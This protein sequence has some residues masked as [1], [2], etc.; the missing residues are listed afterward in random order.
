MSV[1]FRGTIDLAF[2]ALFLD[3]E[4][5]FLAQFFGEE[6]YKKGEQTGRIYEANAGVLLIIV[7]V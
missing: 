1:Y 7:A 5:K 2:D 3:K 6:L 4:E